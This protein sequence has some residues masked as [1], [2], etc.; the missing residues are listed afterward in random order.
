MRNSENLLIVFNCCMM[1]KEKRKSRLIEQLTTNLLYSFI[2]YLS[3]NFKN[4]KKFLNQITKYIGNKSI[5]TN[6]TNNIKN[7]KNIDKTI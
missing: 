6:K 5:N 7:L 4:I 2:E 3:F 1:I